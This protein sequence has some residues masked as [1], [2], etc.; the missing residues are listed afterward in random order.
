LNEYNKFGRLI[1][2]VLKIYYISGAYIFIL[3]EKPGENE[4]RDLKF[5]KTQVKF[6][7]Y[8]FDRKMNQSV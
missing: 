8:L 4:A 1:T 3:L 6:G 5:N 7:V 2:N